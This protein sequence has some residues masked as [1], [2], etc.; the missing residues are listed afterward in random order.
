MRRTDSEPHENMRSIV[1][2]ST[3]AAALVAGCELPRAEPEIHLIP[4]GYVGWVTIA[5]RAVHGEAPV[6]EGNARLYRIPP[7]GTLITRATPNVGSSPPWRFFF[8]DPEG[9]R[10]PITHFDMQSGEAVGISYMHRGSQQGGQ[11]PCHVEY[12]QYFVGTRAQLLSAVARGRERD[13]T[14]RQFFTANYRC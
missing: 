10:T 8:E 13:E 5:F 9:R 6:H 12:D 7:S 3:L 1:T 4:K 14:M 2:I 11:V